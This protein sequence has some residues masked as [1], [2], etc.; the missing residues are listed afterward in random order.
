MKH[1]DNNALLTPT[2][3]HIKCVDD[4]HAEAAKYGVATKG[5]IMVPELLQIGSEV[6]LDFLKDSFYI[7]EYGHDPE[8]YHFLILSLSIYAGLNVA[9]KWHSGKEGMDTYLKK[10]LADSPAN[11]GMALLNKHFP[12]SIAGGQGQP[13][14]RKIFAIWLS[15]H[16]PY[17]QLRDP[18]QYTYRAMLA[19]Y[20]LGNS[21]MLEKLGY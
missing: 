16:E 4:F 5:Y 13:F 17:W 7:M 14:F 2:Q 8:L 9:N 20:Q 18:R 3:F 15:M 6:V 21:M 19:G 1:P 11:D 12:P 10:M